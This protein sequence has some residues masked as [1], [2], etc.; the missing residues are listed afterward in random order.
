MSK[1]P[2]SHC[3]HITA[4]ARKLG[5]SWWTYTATSASADNTKNSCESSAWTGTARLDITEER[6][7]VASRFLKAD[8][9]VDVHHDIVQVQEF[10]DEV[11]K[12][13]GRRRA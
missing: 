8:Y 11:K 7:T 12:C 1:T 13:Q 10:C 5:A 6:A 3:R 2:G 4:M 9:L